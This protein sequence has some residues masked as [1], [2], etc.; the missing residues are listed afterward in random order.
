MTIDF[1][2]VIEAK[3]LARQ[4]VKAE[5]RRQGRVKVQLLSGRTI[6]LLAKQWLQEHPQLYA[7]ARE[8]VERLGWVNPNA[9]RK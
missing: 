4:E 6:S 3:R 7:E 8:R 9:T 5:L 2:T 1:A